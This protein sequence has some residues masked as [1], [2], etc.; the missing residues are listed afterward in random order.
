M[1]PSATTDGASGG[2][3]GPICNPMSLPTGIRDKLRPSQAQGKQ[4]PSVAEGWKNLSTLQKCSHDGQGTAHEVSMGS[5]G[6]FK[7]AGGTTSTRRR[8]A[9]PQCGHLGSSGSSAA[10]LMTC[11]PRTLHFGPVLTLCLHFENLIPINKD[12]PP[13]TFTL[14]TPLYRKKAAP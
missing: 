9:R 2:L 1:R 14:C 13:Y 5:G 3:A 7:R 8:A 11:D 6:E 12:G 10:R 4:K